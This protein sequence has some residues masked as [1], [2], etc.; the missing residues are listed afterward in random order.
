MSSK[1]SSQRPLLAVLATGAAVAAL[2]A[3]ATATAADNESAR[4]DTTSPLASAP[5]A[6]ERMG[7]YD[8]RAVTTTTARG[9]A[10]MRSAAEASQRLGDVVGRDAMVDVDALTGTPRNLATWEGFLTAPS[11]APA[12]TV[13]LDYVR[14]HH[15]ALGLTRADLRT[16]HLRED[17]VDVGGT[18][19]L[20]WTQ[21][22]RGLQ[23][24]GNGLRAHVTRDGELVA[25]Q[26]SPVGG[27]AARAGS[28]ATTPGMSA[29]TARS[30]AADDVGGTA[31]DS[32]AER[33]AAGDLTRWSNGDRAELMWFVTPQG[34]RLG[35][36]TY[37]DA[38]DGLLYTHVIDADSGA[39]LYRRDLVDHD[40]GDAKVRD[41][42]PGAAKGGTTRVVNLFERGWLRRSANW[43][44]GPNVSA[45]ADLNDDNAPNANEKTPVPGTPT[46]AQFSLV[47]L[48]NVSRLCSE[49]FV[50]TWD[51]NTDFSWR[52]NKRADVTNG[53]YLANRFHD[54][55]K[56]S[57]VGFTAAAG[58]FER[59]DG[60]PVL[61]HSLDGANTGGGVPDLN[62]VDNANMS[63]PPDGIPPVMQMFLFHAPGA[64][65][66]QDPFL[67]TSS[68]FAADV[69]YHEYT[70][71]L[72]NRLVVDADG[73][74]TL[75]GIQAGSMGEAWSDYFAMDFLVNKGFQN[76]SPST[77]G[78]VLVGKY[79]SV[80]QPLI[81]TQ[82]IDCPLDATARLCT[83]ANGDKG[84]YT[85]GD[86]RT[87]GAGGPEVHDSGEIWAQTLWDLRTALG[88]AKANRLIA[89]GME[90]SASN[91]SFLDMRNAIVQADKIAFGSANTDAIWRVFAHRG[92]GWFAAAIDGGDASPVENFR[93]PPPAQR[94]RGTLAGFV[95]DPVTDEV[96]EG[97][98]VTVAGHPEYSDTTAPNGVYQIDEIRPGRYPKVVATGPGYEIV[99]DSAKV[100][101]GGFRQVDF[102]VRRN[103]ATSTGGAVLEDFNGP[104]LSVFGCPPDAAIDNSQGAGWGSTTGNDA[105]DPTGTPIPK[106]VEVSLPQPITVSAGT[107]PDAGTAFRV[108]P[109]NV[110]GDP[111]SAAT[112]EY[113]IEVSSNGTT[114]TEV[115]DDG[116][117]T[118]DDPDTVGRYFDVPSTQ[119]VS[120]VR[121]VRFWMDSPQVPDFATNCPDGPFAGC[122]FMD[123]TEF[124]VF[125]TPDN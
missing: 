99:V 55:L 122:Q 42:Y 47:R 114:W 7:D 22:V 43:L 37:T 109:S 4:P 117:G 72:S 85:Y 98:V 68:S 59:A 95:R 110:C 10:L 94:P 119:T 21:S 12:R 88:S 124:Q 11:P 50:C 63:T 5:G 73:N 53:F 16:F 51:P 108:D 125:G 29:G 77:D 13:A 15:G 33:R 45:W 111:A 100:P 35:W 30:T 25:L 71:G 28:A 78:K 123:M 106:F 74:S 20:S 118:I 60:D 62:H 97:A 41:Y 19:H 96:V 93:L 81:R 18:H 66:N 87:V 79:V 9:P 67:P 103:W 121:F 54:W 107:D 75:N 39:V 49:Q 89:R 2:V 40:R 115:A 76:D 58:N 48:N 44:T 65:A 27:L 101:S 92:M 8:A 26:G 116:F 102:Q 24:F 82:A 31:D 104:D 69:L 57:S 80:N 6:R 86:F 64:T 84:G 23:V 90:L 113:R 52:K 3:P 70:H 120:D 46:S 14:A 38:G 105:G 34:L 61:L 1:A 36:S 112:N 83:D 17:Y 32:A 56:N 91:P